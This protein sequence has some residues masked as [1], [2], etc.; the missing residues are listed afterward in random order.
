MGSELAR[1]GGRTNGVNRLANNWRW[2]APKGLWEL[3]TGVM[4]AHEMDSKPKQHATVSGL[5]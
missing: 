2:T 1:L 3:V 5:R 4:S